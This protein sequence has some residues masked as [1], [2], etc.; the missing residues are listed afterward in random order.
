[1]I[2]V[3]YA[4]HIQTTSWRWPWL[5]LA[6]AA[7]RPIVRAS[8]SASST[9]LLGGRRVA[10]MEKSGVD[11]VVVGLVMG[12]VVSAYPAA[13][14]DLERATDLFREFRS[15]RRRSSRRTAT[16]G[17]RSAISPNARLQQQFHPW[18]SYVIVPLFALANAG[19]VLS[20]SFLSGA[21]TSPITLG[22]LVGYVVGKP[23]GIVGTAW[24]VT[25]VLAVGYGRRLAG[26]PSPVVAPSPA[27]ASRS[28]S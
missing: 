14:V 9:S 19:I 15:S 11:P 22:I 1:M 10:L 17:V 24:L 13:R 23:V 8:T 12:L 2:A 28:R 4:E 7:G 26:P 27:S 16:A 21:F 5:V 3:V 18:T 6:V 25:T 20:W